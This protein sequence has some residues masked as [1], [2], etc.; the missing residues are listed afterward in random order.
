MVVEKKLKPAK[1]SISDEA[2]F[3]EFYSNVLS[4]TGVRNPLIIRRNFSGSNP[5]NKLEL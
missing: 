5:I 3:E 2:P 4:A 1:I